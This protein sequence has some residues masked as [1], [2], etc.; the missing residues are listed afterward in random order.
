VL[1][2]PLSVEVLPGLNGIVRCVLLVEADQH[3]D[4]LAADGTLSEQFGAD[5]VNTR[6]FTDVASQAAA[7]PLG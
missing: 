6:D 3:V 1:G 2:E 7:G 5:R 4:K